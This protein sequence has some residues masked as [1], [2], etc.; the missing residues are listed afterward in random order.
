MILAPSSL[1][2]YYEMA[3]NHFKLQPNVKASRR[4]EVQSL[5]IETIQFPI[6]QGLVLLRETKL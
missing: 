3:V 4:R 2:G 5:A 6:V 1:A